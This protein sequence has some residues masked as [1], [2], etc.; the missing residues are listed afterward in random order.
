MWAGALLPPRWGAME[1]PDRDCSFVDLLDLLAFS[2]ARGTRL[3]ML[4]QHE[5]AHPSRVMVPKV[6]S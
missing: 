3:L 6:L 1:E 4:P 5:P 2:L